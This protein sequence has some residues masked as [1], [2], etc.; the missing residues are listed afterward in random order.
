M[1]KLIF[2]LFLLAIFIL[3]SGG[4]H[5]SIDQ[6]PSDTSSD[7]YP[8][9]Y[10]GKIAWVAWDGMDLEVYYWDG[11]VTSQITDN[12]TADKHPSLHNGAIAWQG[13]DKS[14][15]PGDLEIY[16]W[17]GSNIAQVTD[18]NTSD[19]KPSL[20]GGTIAWQGHDGNDFEIYYW[21]GSTIIQVT[22]NNIEDWNPSLHDGRIAWMG[23][24]GGE[25]GTGDWEIYYW[26]GSTIAQVTDNNTDDSNPS[27]YN[28]TIAWEGDGGI[29]YWNSTT[30]IQVT[31]NRR[32]WGPS[33]YNG[34]IAWARYDS[35]DDTFGTTPGEI[36][37]WNGSTIRQVTNDNTAIA[38]PPSL[39]DGIIAWS[40][41]GE[42][43]HCDAVSTFVQDGIQVDSLV[44]RNAVGK[45]IT[46]TGPI[47]MDPLWVTLTFT[48]TDGN[49]DGIIEIGG[50]SYGLPLRVT[51]V[52]KGLGQKNTKIKKR[53]AGTFT[54][55]KKFGPTGEWCEQY[56]AAHP[57]ECPGGQPP[58][59]ANAYIKGIVV[60]KKGVPDQGMVE[61]FRSKVNRQ[62]TVQ[63]PE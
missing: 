25:F 44:I 38:G 18:N 11:I 24:E 8:S 28:T 45:E 16:Y 40:W 21:N 13:W 43:Y 58:C 36:Y 33:L 3:A 1:K 9:V 47:A 50:E 27:L 23:Y 26:D 59:D 31:S 61:V 22:D 52:L 55:I 30:I 54:F 20:Y 49:D 60:M 32:D 6:I 17:N 57:A 56:A 62:L 35:M 12:T 4:G 7:A 5:A 53:G 63:C 46:D 15:Y 41:R 19:E 14:S 48:I 37:Y 29:S 51:T 2:A 34:T 10:D 39:Y 42:I